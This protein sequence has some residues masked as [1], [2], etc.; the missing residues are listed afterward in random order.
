MNTLYTDIK[1]SI[2]EAAKISTYTTDAEEKDPLY[3][4]YGVRSVPLKAIIQSHKKHIQALTVE[5]RLSLIDKLVSS[6]YGEEQSIAIYIMTLMLGYYTPDTF[7]LLETYIQHFHGWSKID[8][9]CLDVLQPILLQYPADTLSLLTRW[10]QAKNP[11]E[12][13]AS[14]VT[15]TRKIGESGQYTEEA[16]QL[17]QNIIHDTE[18]FVLK[19]VGWCLKD[20][21][22]GNRDKVLPYIMALKKQKVS[23]LVTAYALRDSGKITKWGIGIMKNEK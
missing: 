17:C 5:E 9:F 14:V 8:G 18:D 22:R 20:N 3:K 4:A 16:L 2:L 1:S 13:R 23:P 15:L 21:L 7:S 12:K 11:W 6:E 19:G 10:N